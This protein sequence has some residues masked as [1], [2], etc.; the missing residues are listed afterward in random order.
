MNCQT[1]NWFCC[2]QFVFII[3]G[4]V[5]DHGCDDEVD[6]DPQ[7]VVEHEPDEGQD[8]E[9]VSDREP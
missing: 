2:I 3:E 8:G 7:G 4:G 6:V 5:V 1:Y 9:D